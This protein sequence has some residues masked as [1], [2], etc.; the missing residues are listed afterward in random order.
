MLCVTPLQHRDNSGVPACVT[1]VT[2]RNATL[3]FGRSLRDGAVRPA[4]RDG[5][6]EL[7]SLWE[8]PSRPLTLPH[9]VTRWPALVRDSC[10]VLLGWEPLTFIVTYSPNA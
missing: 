9:G 10:G 4:Q 3:R 6:R 1:F 7:A 5:T 8:R 2:G